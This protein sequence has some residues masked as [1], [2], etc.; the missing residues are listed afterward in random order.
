M[1]E[2]DDDLDESIHDMVDSDSDDMHFSEHSEVTH[3]MATYSHSLYI[4]KAYYIYI[5]IYI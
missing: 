3:C 4:V 2:D 1:Y 5:Y